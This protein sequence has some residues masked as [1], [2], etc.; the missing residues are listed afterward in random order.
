MRIRDEE[1][2]DRE[3]VAALVVSAFA[4]RPYASG[5]EARIHA[6]LHDAGAATVALVAEDTGR[7]VG[8]VIV[9]PVTLDGGPSGWHGLGPVAVLPERQGQGIGSGLIV[10]A[11]TR[12]RGLGSGGCVLLGD[13]GYYGRFGFRPP[14][15]LH[16]PG[17]P[18]E[19]LFVLP[20]GDEPTGA[21]GYHPAFGI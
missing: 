7:V 17:L 5:T 21:V 1:G 4:G 10:E 18:A 12:L 15:G 13:G 8:Q 6:A 9:S 16:A 20:F 14:R 19:H 11:L 3:A 2:G